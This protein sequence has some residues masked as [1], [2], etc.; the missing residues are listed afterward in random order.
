MNQYDLIDCSAKECLTS[1]KSKIGLHI[2]QVCGP[3]PKSF[4][5]LWT[6]SGGA[7]ALTMWDLESPVGLM[8]VGAPGFNLVKYI[9]ISHILWYSSLTYSIG[10]YLLY[11]MTVCISCN[12]ICSWYQLELENKRCF[13]RKLLLFLIGRI[14]ITWKNLQETQKKGK[15]E[16]IFW[17]MYN[18]K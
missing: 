15:E 6:N 16:F 18:T 11:I 14:F 7:Y 3:L 2:S 5:P 12:I 8:T 4:T 10:S 17:T 1:G 9:W 13:I